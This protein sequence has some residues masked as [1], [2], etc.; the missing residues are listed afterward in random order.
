MKKHDTQKSIPVFLGLGSNVEPVKHLVAALN[1]L[2]AC[3]GVLR[4]SPVY[5][6][7]AV[8]FEGE[9]FLNL[10]VGFDTALTMHDV[11]RHIREIE[12]ANGRV[13]TGPKFG[14]RT[15]DIDLL[16]YGDFVGSE[17]GVRVPRDEIVKNAFVLLPLSDIAPDR[18]HPECQKTYLELWQ[19]YQSS[20]R[21]W[22]ADFQWEQP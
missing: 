19:S 14:P 11:S 1:A 20:Q 10:V 2:R 22:R 21:L 3:F 8:G 18:R 17:A 6:S 7:E 16:T 15:L 13:R 4:V 9:N 12:D 5:E